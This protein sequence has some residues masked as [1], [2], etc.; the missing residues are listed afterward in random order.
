MNAQPQPP[1]HLL[2]ALPLPEP[3]DIDDWLCSVS[4]EGWPTESGEPLIHSLGGDVPANERN[5]LRFRSAKEI[6]GS[7]SEKTEFAAPYLAFGAITELDGKP[8]AAGKTTYV[9]AM[10]GAILDGAPFLGHATAKGPVVMLTEQPP[11]S[12]RAALLRA[13]LADRDDFILLS[14]AE[15]A[16]T[17]WP[18][19]VDMAA[20]ACRE[21]GSRVLIVDTLPQF[22][23]LRGDAE[24]NAGDAL[25][26]IG[27]LQLLAAE[28]FAI[29]VT[30]HDR[31]AGGEVGESARGS[32]AF[33]GAV[34]I[35]LALGREPQA[36]RPTMR[37][38]GCLSRFEETEPDL[39]IELVGAR[40]EVI[41]TSAEALAAAQ[42]E[43]LIRVLGQEPTKLEE[44]AEA[45]GEPVPSVRALL[46]TLHGERLVRRHGAGRR[47][48][49][50]TWS[51][52]PGDCLLSFRPP[53]GDS[54]K[55][56]KSPYPNDYSD[57]AVEDDYPPS[58]FGDQ[59]N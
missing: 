37:H 58:A 14:W 50:Y 54:R 21:I 7:V 40:Y 30:R 34:D 55:E 53:T 6:C 32:G 33:T 18:E 8:K 13:G 56:S 47:G 27:P 24:N 36:S 9:L 43:K 49:P 29:L 3:D 42:R 17:A 19:I 5:R 23:G 35:V 41:G 10:T 20:D 51:R 45:I 1:L 2:T 57:L 59:E 22:A 12:L 28:G 48:D 52:E 39:V 38:L 4:D 31:K 11:A 15:A 25:E 46:N 26:A 44:I 16:G